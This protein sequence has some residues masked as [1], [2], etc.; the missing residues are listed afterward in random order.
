MNKSLL[1][2]FVVIE[3]NHKN[4]YEKTNVLLL[5]GSKPDF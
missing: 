4:E 3:Q 2:N 1:E 5:Y